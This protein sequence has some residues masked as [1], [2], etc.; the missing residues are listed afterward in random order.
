MIGK[1]IGLAVC[2]AAIINHAGAQELGIELNGGLQGMRYPLQN[3]ESKPLPGGSLGLNYTFQL[4]KGWGLLTGIAGGLYRTEASLNDGMVLSY[5]QVD[6]AGSAFQYNL[7]PTGYKETQQFFA[8][9][10]PLL[11]QYHTADA[12]MQWYFN[13][14]G[15]VLFPFN[16][17]IQVSAQQLSLSGYYPDFNLEV[18]NLPQHGFG[19]VNGWKASATTQLKPAAALSAATGL[20][21]G[22]SSGTRLYAGVFVDYGLTGLKAKHDSMPVITYSPAGINKVQ[23]NSVLNTQNAGQAKLLS[24]GLEVRLSFG[25]THAKATVPPKTKE[26]LPPPPVVTPTPRPATQPPQPKTQPPPPTTQPPPPTTQPPP[27]TTPDSSDDLYEVLRNP[28][29]FGI[30]GETS[31]SEIQ[32]QHLDK[33][34]NLM[35][36]YSDIRISI[37]GHICDGDNVTENKK[38]GEARAKAVAD[39]LRSKGI[40]RRRMDISPDVVADPFVSYDPQANYR[41][42]KVVITEE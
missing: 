29:V 27:P 32:Q 2:L 28:V 10:I 15:K 17:T 40:D 39:Y 30:P 34:A 3:G 5:D 14:G 1:R 23:A 35:K 18:S 31:I 12:G 36:Q 4:S 7:K 37:V 9:T 16:S 26:E 19:T 38:V 21:F 8:A 20:S 11:L 25:P 41:N 24:F 13:G 33:I 6:D 42:R 22:I